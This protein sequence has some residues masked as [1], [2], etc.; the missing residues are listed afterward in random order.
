[1]LIVGIPEESMHANAELVGLT[2]LS[3]KRNRRLCSSRLIFIGTGLGMAELES[4]GCLKTDPCLFWSMR[5]GAIHNRTLQDIADVV[6]G[7]ECRRLVK[8]VFD[9]V[10]LCSVFVHDLPQ[11]FLECTR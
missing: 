3:I 4:K 5:Y 11:T 2:S 7:C 6:R 10:Q 1:M 9:V 8:L